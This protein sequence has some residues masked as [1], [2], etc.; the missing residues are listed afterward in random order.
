MSNEI[1]V[2]MTLNVKNGGLNFTSAP[3]AF[4]DNQSVIGGPSPDTYVIP[5]AGIDLSF[6]QILGNIYAPITSPGWCWMCN[7]DPT[8]YVT[9]GMR[10]ANAGTW[11][12]I[13]ELD[14]IDSQGNAHPHLLKLSRF[15]NEEM[16]GTGTH[17]GVNVATLHFRPN[18]RTACKVRICIFE[19]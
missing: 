9:W 17:Q 11:Y 5:A 13:G 6:T 1:S 8:N 16:A 19:R 2:T 14:P 4:T 12:P 18:N 7:L 3:S 15:I 10:D